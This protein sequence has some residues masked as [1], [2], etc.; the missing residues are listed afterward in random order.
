MS[1][2]LR[3]Q[4]DVELGLL[5]RSLKE[6]GPL[7]AKCAAQEPDAIERSALAAMLHAFYTGIETIFKRV[8]VEK[9]TS[10]WTDSAFSR[11]T[12]IAR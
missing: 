12:S 9:N 3:R 10:F 2:K 11:R 4:V 7:I 6:F 1:S 8:A 5:R